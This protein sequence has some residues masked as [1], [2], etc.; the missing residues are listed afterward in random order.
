VQFGDIEILPV[1]DGEGKL[2][3]DYLPTL[4]WKKHASMLDADGN[5]PISLGCF[6]IKT[7]GR[8]ILV[9]AGLGPV[10][11]PPFRG[12]DLPGNL[13][14]AGVTPADVDMVIITHLHVDHIGWLVQNGRP[15]FPKATV[16]FGEKDLDQFIRAENPDPFAK[17]MLDVLDPAG[18]IETV[19]GDDT[20]APGVNVMQTPGHT[21]GHISVVV[22][23]GEERAFLLGDAMACPAQ[24]EDAEWAAMSDIDPKLS[25]RSREALFK[26][27][28]SPGA[29]AVASHF[30]DLSFGRVLRGQGKRY[31]G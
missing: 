7:A 16:R 26:E 22:S 29:L 12:G 6:L 3:S 11:F 28:E 21:L 31:F 23:S 5:F 14:K 19:A 27:M 1:N 25:T 17:P 20:V 24:L 18:R 15:Y 10:T 8:N 2:P 4:D 13:A 30:P 9:D